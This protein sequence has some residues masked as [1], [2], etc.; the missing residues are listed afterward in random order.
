MLP[1]A[2]LDREVNCRRAAAAALQECVGRLSTDLF[3]EGIRL[4][5]VADYFSLGD[6]NSAYLSLAP[7]VAG[8]ADGIYF[9]CI[10]DE[11]W[12][13]KLVHWDIT[14]RTLAAK[15]LAA[16]VAV[17]EENVIASRVLPELLDM[18]T[19]RG[20]PVIR[21]GATLGIA[22]VF[23]AVHTGGLRTHGAAIIE[24]PVRCV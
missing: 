8:L 17:D 23:N 11:V 1:V 20:D 5:T 6:R 19:R 3:R 22:E 9:K 24:I 2:L 13:R 15:A 18:A 10:V 4:I 7:E 21:H 12:M 14:I 16:L